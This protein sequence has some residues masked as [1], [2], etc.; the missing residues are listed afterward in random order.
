MR[1]FIVSE[2]SPEVFSHIDAERPQAIGRD[3]LVEVKAVSLNPNDAIMKRISLGKTLGYDASGIVREVGE[4]VRDFKVGDEVIY[5]G[6]IDRSG[7]NSEYHLV[8]ERV[9]SRRPYNMDFLNAATFPYASVTAFD[10]LF[11]KLEVDPETSRGKTIL[12][13][14]G[15]SCIGVM[16]TQLAKQITN[17]KVLTTA[18]NNRV[19]H[20][21]VGMGAHHVLNEVLPLEMQLQ[22]LDI[23]QIDYVLCTHSPSRYI[24][25]L[26]DILNEKSRMTSLIMVNDD[27]VAEDLVEAI[28]DVEQEFIFLGPMENIDKESQG[29]I[30]REITDLIEAGA[31]KS[32]LTNDLGAI[33]PQSLN[34]GHRLLEEGKIMGKIALSFH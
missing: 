14:D 32:P 24:A 22:S 17:L 30:L 9:V 33:T 8:D 4:N 12:I 29:E 20:Y 7:S 1:T 2:T 18:T 28:P 13:T 34:E 6:E 16:A 23:E 19:L 31:L 15:G 10:A 3:L 11:D 21:S 26:R 5:C 25:G 27:F